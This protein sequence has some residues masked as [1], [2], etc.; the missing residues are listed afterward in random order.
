VG[1]ANAV[2]RSVEHVNEA[3]SPRLCTASNDDPLPLADLCEIVTELVLVL[4]IGV[5][6]GLTAPLSGLPA[7][8][9]VEVVSLGVANAGEA[10]TTTAD[11][12]TSA[13]STL[14]LSAFIDL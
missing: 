2:A 8:V 3:A 5:K 9:L 12:S 14:L 4:P 6:N 13:T 1:P 11:T 10:T 7:L